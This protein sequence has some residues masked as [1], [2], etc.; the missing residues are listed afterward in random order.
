[1]STIPEEDRFD[2]GAE[3]ATNEVGQTAAAPPQSQPPQQPPQQQEQ[4]D[5]LSRLRAERDD[6]YNRLARVTADY[7]NARK[8]LEAELEQRMAYANASLIK[9]LLPV[10]DNFERALAVDPQ[11]TDAAS[12][13]KGLQV[14]HDQWMTVLQSQAVREIAPKP[15]DPFNPEL[16]QALMQQ[17]DERFKDQPP[18]VIQLLQ[19][20][21]MLNDRVL[22]PAQ[23]V[24]SKKQS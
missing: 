1:M 19:K 22:R 5:E 24:V 15:G 16:H 23:V 3:V 10:I 8:R 13:L 6:L 7:Q 18:T 4:A 11:K 2:A 14:V 9:A 17:E 20:G 21:Y 12:I